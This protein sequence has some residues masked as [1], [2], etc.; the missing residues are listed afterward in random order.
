M[1]I[2]VMGNQVGIQYCQPAMAVHICNATQV[3]E[4]GVI[5]V[6]VKPI[7]WSQGQHGIQCVSSTA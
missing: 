2:E 4:L 6:N 5:A 1:S 3:G 7:H